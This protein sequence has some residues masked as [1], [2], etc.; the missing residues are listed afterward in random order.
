MNATTTSTSGRVSVAR[1][2]HAPI[3]LEDQPGGSQQR[4]AE[5]DRHPVSIEN[6]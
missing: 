1:L 2:L 4:V 5:H 3:G 6:G